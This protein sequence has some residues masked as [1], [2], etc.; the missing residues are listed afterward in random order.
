[1][2]MKIVQL[3]I[4]Q[5]QSHGTRYIY[6]PWLPQSISTLNM[7]VLHNEYTKRSDCV[8]SSGE[9]NGKKYNG[10]IAQTGSTITILFLM[11]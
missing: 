2:V 6:M 3:L 4:S 11:D 7:C 8:M 9:L 1:M 5:A 10:Y